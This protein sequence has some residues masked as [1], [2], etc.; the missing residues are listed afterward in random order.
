MKI[1]IDADACP[2]IVKE[3]IFKASSRLK[4]DVCLV[5][6]SHLNI[7]L[8]PYISFVKVDLGADIADQYIAQNVEKIDLVI[9]ADIPLAALVVE[10]EATAINP[11]GEVYTE[12][13]IAERLSV[14]NFMQELRDSGMDTGGPP[15]LG[16]KDKEKFT[17]SFD[18][19]MT[20]LLKNL[21]D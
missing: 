13:N 4:V 20:K 3:V 16:P 8:S 12:E 21:K 14:R 18:K 7:P 1:W 10:K 19:I 2:K 5:A 6:N 15:P 17:N 9:T 11:R